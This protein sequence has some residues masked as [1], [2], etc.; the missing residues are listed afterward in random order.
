M[1]LNSRTYLNSC[2]RRLP[3]NYIKKRLRKKNLKRKTRSGAF[4]KEHIANLDG[5]RRTVSN[6]PSLNAR[7]T[8]QSTWQLNE[9]G[10]TSPQPFVSTQQE[11]I[12]IKPA[13]K[14]S[15]TVV[16]DMDWYEN[17]CLRQLNNSQFYEKI[18]KDLTPQTHELNVSKDTFPVYNLTKWLL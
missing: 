10:K 9:T 6:G 2:H 17:E 3:R 12:I 11:D 8:M 5:G 14:G 16:M 7:P 15:D 18:D 1:I 4:S 13:D